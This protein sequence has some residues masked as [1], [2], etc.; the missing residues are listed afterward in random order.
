MV[1]YLFVAFCGIMLI[2]LYNSIES[3]QPVTVVFQ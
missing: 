1:L 2:M 3:L